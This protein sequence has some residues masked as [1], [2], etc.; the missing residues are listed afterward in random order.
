M[1]VTEEDR[2]DEERVNVTDTQTDTDRRNSHRQKLIL[3]AGRLTR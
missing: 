2:V 3:I 1:I